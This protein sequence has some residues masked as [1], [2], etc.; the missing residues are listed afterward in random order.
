MSVL[1]R[2][3]GV[4]MAVVLLVLLSLTGCPSLFEPQPPVASFIVNPSFGAAVSDTI[5]LNG[6]TSRDPQGNTLTYQWSL[7]GPAGSTAFLYPDY[8]PL[9]S[10]QADKPGQYTVVLTVT[11]GSKS[12]TASKTITVTGAATAAA[13]TSFG[14]VNPPAAGTID[15]SAKTIAVSVPFGTNVT[16]LVA[17]FTTMG[18]S[19]KVNNVAQ[20]SGTTPNDFTGPVTYLVTASDSSTA[21]YSVTATV[22]DASGKAITSFGFVSPPVLGTIDESAKTITV[23]VPS[24]TVVTALVATFTTTGASVQVNAVTQTSGTTP[25]DFTNAV[26]YLVTASDSSTVSYTVTVVLSSIDPIVGK[27]QLSTE[28]GQAASTIPMAMNLTISSDTNWIA[29]GSQPGQPMVTYGTWSKQSQGNYS[30]TFA[31]G[32]PTGV[33]NMSLVLSGSTLTGTFTDADGTQTFVFIP[34]TAVLPDPIIGNWHLSSTTPP[35]STPQAMNFEFKSDNKTWSMS[36]VQTASSISAS[37]KWNQDSPGN[38]TITFTSGGPGVSSMLF[39]LSSGTLTGTFINNQVQTTWILHTGTLDLPATIN[40]LPSVFKTSNGDY[41][42]D[43]KDRAWRLGP[44]ADGDYWSEYNYMRF[45]ISAD[46]ARFAEYLAGSQGNAGFLNWHTSGTEQK[47]DF[48]DSNLHPLYSFTVLHYSANHLHLRMLW[49]TETREWIFSAGTSNVSGLVVDSNDHYTQNPYYYAKPLSGASVQ[50][51]TMDM[52]GGVFT[53]IPGF[54]TTTD[55]RGFFEFSDLTGYIGQTLMAKVT[56]VGY[57]DIVQGNPFDT[58]TSTSTVFLNIGLDLPAPIV[59]NWHLSSMTPTPSSLPSMNFVFNSNGTWTASIAE[60]GYSSSASGNWS[61]NSPGN[62]YIG[63]ISGGPGD[64]S[65]TFT[66]SNGTLSG[67]YFDYQSQQQ[68]TMILETGVGDLPATGDPIVGTWSL[69]RK[70]GDL[71]SSLSLTETVVF[72]QYNGM[73]LEYGYT[74]SGS[75]PSGPYSG[76]GSWSL[77]STNNYEIIDMSLGRVLTG[78]LSNNNQ[79]LTTNFTDSWEYQRAP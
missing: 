50:L 26:Q 70:N 13:I 7:V 44:A 4:G 76:N 31:Y 60:T 73:K 8:G 1:H 72:F 9:V 46:G 59:G 16:A 48:L 75:N 5:I 61:Q 43:F 51:G 18:T 10:F 64:A 38:Y 77:V 33:Q 22:A 63:F 55:A 27:W 47:L 12:S 79:T 40:P 62:Y 20:V 24:G 15:E 67:T 71:A 14:F 57:A 53:P 3:A 36:G 30:M 23:T 11:A 17:T 39:T 41:A 21:T 65:T 32:G 69:Y 58:V 78:V 74:Y 68:T 25:N 35:P 49:G 2:N 52:L 42:Q 34:G 28:N 29:I 37:G 56:K 54:A 66:L 19:V 45:N 6:T